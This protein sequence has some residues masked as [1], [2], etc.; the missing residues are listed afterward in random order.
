MGIGSEHAAWIQTLS[1]FL[2]CPLGL[3]EGSE[4][5]EADAA[6][7][8]LEGVMGPPHSGITT[9][10]LVKL[11]VT[12][13]DDG[14][15]DVW[16]LVFFFVDKRRVAERDKC[17]LTVEWREGQWARRGWEADAEGEWAGLETLE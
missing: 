15:L 9:E 8:T 16:A 14:G 10:L 7:S 5:L 6:S 4:T 11:L 1:G 2:G 17:Y 12:R 13:R 3:V